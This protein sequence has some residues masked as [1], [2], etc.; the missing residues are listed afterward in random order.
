M[1]TH[2]N[3]N[4]R[5]PLQCLLALCGARWWLRW[6]LVQMYAPQCIM[7]ADVIRVGLVLIRGVE[8]SCD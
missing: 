6:G 5:Y 2:R 3:R 4:V 1:H 7:M 8:A